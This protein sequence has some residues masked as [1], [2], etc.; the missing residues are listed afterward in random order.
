MNL[1]ALAACVLFVVAGSCVLTGLAV[2]ACALL[3]RQ[4]HRELEQAGPD[5]V[6]AGFD[7]V[8]LDHG[9]DEC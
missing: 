2:Y 8:G 9:D 3:T 1:V 5:G 7:G 4:E 6:P